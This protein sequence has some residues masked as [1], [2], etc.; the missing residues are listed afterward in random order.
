MSAK[1]V[2][3]EGTTLSIK[4][5][6]A[7]VVLGQIHEIDGPNVTV[8]AVP[9][10]NLSSTVMTTRPS[11]L[12]TPEKFT[13]K[14]WFDPSDTA[15]QGVLVGRANTP[16]VVDDWKVIFVNDGNTTPATGTF[17]GFVT[18]FKVTGIKNEENIGADVEIQLTTIVTYTAGTP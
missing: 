17:S 5:S 18:S 15:G 4:I 7:F 3:G 1:V 8:K 6:A 9:N 12:T 2:A 10:A 13:A 11:H 14:M 16:G